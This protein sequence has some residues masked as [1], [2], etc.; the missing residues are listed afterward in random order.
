[1]SKQRIA[2]IGAGISGLILADHL[3]HLADTSLTL[4]E[5]SRS[6]GGRMASRYHDDFLFDHGAQFFV[7]KKK[8]FQHYIK[9]YIDA[10]I[11]CPWHARFVEIDGDKIIA[12]RQW[13]DPK[14]PHYVATPK[15]NAW[16][17]A[18]AKNVAVLCNTEIINIEKK[19]NQWALTAHDGEKTY[20]DWVISTM[21]A[22][23][24]AARIPKEI[25]FHPLIDSISMK[26]CYAL[27]LGL[28]PS[29]PPPFD[30]A[31]IKNSPLSWLSIVSSKPKRHIATS[32]VA[33][34]SNQWA[35]DH[36]EHD[37]TT[38]QSIL[39]NAV[40]NYYPN[41]GTIKH[42]DLHRWRYAN[43]D[44]QIGPQFHMDAVNKIACCGDWLIQGRV[45][46]AYISATALAKNIE[47]IITT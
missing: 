43:I 12:K 1:M 33:L 3:Q 18:I 40:K 10:E 5:K 16:A 32:L 42:I 15:M 31:L 28:D 13:G 7:A 21:P 8:A 35:S 45:E 24:A 9:P 36:L 19:N 11:L 17:K 46:A 37:K 39:L 27:M 23:Q 34:A 6:V 47:K 2:I 30:A 41:L 22:P 29:E 20:F 14:H 26:P 44:K 38:V 25:A 4:F